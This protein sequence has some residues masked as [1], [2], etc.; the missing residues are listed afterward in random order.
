[1]ETEHQPET[2]DPNTPKPKKA[3]NN[4]AKFSSMALQMG[5]AIGGFAWLGTFL[6][7]K[8]NPGGQAW[9]ICL[10]LFGVAAALYLMIREVTR[11]SK[12]N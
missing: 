4:Y 7:R 1:M 8:Y 3:L 11:M 6:D 9:T 10:S 2:N 12:D 5:V